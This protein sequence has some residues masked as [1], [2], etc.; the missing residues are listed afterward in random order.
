MTTAV[1]RA[2]GADGGGASTSYFVD[3]RKG[4]VNELK[5]LL[6]NV[7][8]ERDQRRKRDVIKKVIAYM[9]LGIDVS[10]LFAEMMLAIETRDVVIKKMVYHYLSTY[11]VE[12]PDMAIMA[13][14]TMQRDCSNEDP[15]IRGLAL[16]ALCNLGLPSVVEYI[17]DPLQRSL[18]DPNAYVRK[19]AVMGLLKVKYIDADAVQDSMINTL[20]D[21]LR[22]PDA[23]VVT[24]CIMVLNEL[25]VE[26]GGMAINQAIVLHLLN[27]IGEFNEWS[28]CPVLELVARYTP[29]DEE[30]TF[31]IMNLLDPVL[32]TSNSGVVLA[33]VKCFLSLTEAMPDMHWQVY[34]RLK[35]PLLT[36]M[37]SGSPESCY[38]L[39]SH[40]RT[41]VHRCPGVFNVDFR[42]FYVRFNEPTYVKF[43]KMELLASIAA[44]GSLPDIVGE[45]AECVSD[46]NAET[47]RR[48]IRAIAR[49]GL[50][51]PDGVAV[52][53]ERLLEF[54]SLDADY[55][56]AE[57]AIVMQDLLRKHP[58]RRNDVLPA[59]CRCLRGMAEPGGRA[60]IV[61]ILGEFGADAREAP[62]ALEPLIDDYAEETD[63]GVRLQ[64]LTATMK[65]FFRRPPEVQ[66]MLGR[67]MA[68]A[69]EDT[70]NHD[71]HDRAL[72]Y[73][74]LLQSG[75][76][77]ARAVVGTDERAAALASFFEDTDDGVLDR[78]FREFNTL[79]V[80][81]NKT[82]DQFIKPG[83]YRPV[84]LVKAPQ[85]EPERRSAARPPAPA[86]APAPY[87]PQPSVA[88]ATNVRDVNDDGL[89]LSGSAVLDG[90]T[91]QRLWM[92]LPEVM[93]D[94]LR[95]AGCP[96]S[97]SYI[98]NTLAAM[99]IM[100]MASGDLE[101]TMKFFLYAQDAASQDVVLAQGL[102]RKEAPVAFDL[103][104][105][106]NFPEP[107]MACIQFVTL[108]TSV[109]T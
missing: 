53:F 7:S 5:S 15:M 81:F 88:A 83:F 66:G 30:E 10:R 77:A 87:A 90:P 60:A 8:T 78:V 37:G 89:N 26:E 69:V 56:Q 19:T 85:P 86:P 27:R 18:R 32:R 41:L 75:A 3:Q 52:I 99:H 4:E 51:L 17:I 14:N 6:R 68:A 39:L 50:R 21:M 70:S 43:I 98:E 25:L 33:T 49:I 44:D 73:Y 102:L 58:E 94:S 48:S 101:D 20:Y 1:G 97:P 57:T 106:S 16:R 107:D 100:T 103:T 34:E 64:L 13:I 29:A 108:I 23:Q 42:H 47:A 80:L 109:L 54:L 92:E 2:I 67:L 61:W 76:A 63:A 105:K 45:L 11:A 9:T 59:L 84:R 46:A 38:C 71:V 79:S 82:S 28:L 55:V 22:D 35:P 104:L 12:K 62:Y 72:L 95:L 40:V 31:N 91:F 96:E 24:N 74:R 36:L 65:L 93:K